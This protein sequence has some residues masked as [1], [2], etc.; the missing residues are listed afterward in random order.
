VVEQASADTVPDNVRVL[1][2]VMK[3]L[4]DAP[5]S[6]VIDPI[7]AVVIVRMTAG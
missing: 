6:V 4:E 7:V 1:S 5:V 2:S 3:S